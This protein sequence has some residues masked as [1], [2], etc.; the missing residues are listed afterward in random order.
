MADFELAY[1]KTAQVE[2]G[3]ANDPDD[4]GGETYK[5]LARKMETGWPGWIMIDKIKKRVGN[6]AS[7][8]NKAAESDTGLQHLVWAAYKTSYWDILTLD[9]LED[10]RVANELYDTGVNMGVGRAALFFQRALNCINRNG[11]LFPDLKLDGQVGQKT[12]AAFNMLSASDKYIVWKLLNC[13]QGEKYIDICEANPTQE[14]FMR[15]WASRVF[16]T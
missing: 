6:S 7:E 5:G 9:K 3:Y 2:G 16:E 13:Q 12:I 1:K 14:K 10:Q 4:R 8:I 11:Q 15:S